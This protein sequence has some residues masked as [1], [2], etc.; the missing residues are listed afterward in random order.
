MRYTHTN[1]F[2]PESELYILLVR[3]MNDVAKDSDQILFS[4]CPVFVIRHTLIIVYI[5]VC[6]PFR[7]TKSFLLTTV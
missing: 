5:A 1:V 3:C 4:S 2:F 7:G 6:F